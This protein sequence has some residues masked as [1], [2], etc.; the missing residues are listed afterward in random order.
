[1]SDVEVFIEGTT[2]VVTNQSAVIGRIAG[3][4]QRLAHAMENSHLASIITEPGT[5]TGFLMNLEALH[6]SEFH[7]AYNFYDELQ[8]QEDEPALQ[9]LHIDETKLRAE[10]HT[11]YE[12]MRRSEHTAQG[13]MVK[14]AGS[15]AYNAR[16]DG[17]AIR[18]SGGLYHNAKTTRD[19]LAGLAQTVVA[20]HQSNAESNDKIQRKHEELAEIQRRIRTLKGTP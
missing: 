15:M 1:M 18:I 14:L 2:L 9:A 12:E 13:D 16:M 11:L 20:L 8:P 3:G 6:S 10:L 4:G 7:T 19:L 17:T 5:S